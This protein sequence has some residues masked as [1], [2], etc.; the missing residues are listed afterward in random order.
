MSQMLGKENK[1]WVERKMVLRNSGDCRERIQI[2]QGEQ[3]MSDIVPLPAFIPR[4]V[5]I[6]F[7]LSVLLLH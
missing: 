3:E 6:C 1:K 5:V 2:I 7:C 4:T